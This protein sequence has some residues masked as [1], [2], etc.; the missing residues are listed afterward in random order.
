MLEICNF[1]R[2]NVYHLSILVPCSCSFWTA[3]CVDIFLTSIQCCMRVPLASTILQVAISTSTNCLG[4]ATCSASHGGSIPHSIPWI[5]LEFLFWRVAQTVLV[6]LE[7]SG[8]NIAVRVNTSNPVSVR[9]SR[10]LLFVRW[11]LGTRSYQMLLSFLSFRSILKEIA[12]RRPSFNE[13]VWRIVMRR[14]SCVASIIH[15]VLRWL[16]KGWREHLTWIISWD[17]HFTWGVLVQNWWHWYRR[18]FWTTWNYLFFLT[19]EVSKLRQVLLLVRLVV[20][21]DLL[22]IIISNLLNLHFLDPIWPFF[23]TYLFKLLLFMV[24]QLFHS[25]LK[26]VWYNQIV[27]DNIL[28]FLIVEVQFLL[29]HLSDLNVKHVLEF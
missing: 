9:L 8:N 2:I 4:L 23:S 29:V 26:L 27:V 21:V 7:E 6:L 18:W 25:S 14:R 28:S 1:L 22:E 16:D 13:T 10:V 15:L 3:V 12:L 24:F 5:I 19:L 11:S 17:F 20:W